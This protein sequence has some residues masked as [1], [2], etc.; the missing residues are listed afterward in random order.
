MGIAK[1]MPL[2]WPVRLTMA[3]LMPTKNSEIT[4]MKASGISLYRI[5]VPILG[6]AALI[7]VGVF[8][9]QDRIL[10]TSNKK[11]MEIKDVIKKG[12]SK[13]YQSINHQWLLGRGNR[14]YHFLSYD[15][16]E[17]TIQ[18][19]YLYDVSDENRMERI[20]VAKNATWRETFTGKDGQRKN[21]WRFYEG[22]DKKFRDMEVEKFRTFDEA[23]FILPEDY[24]FFARENK[25]PQL[26]SYAELNKYI[27]ELKK[28]GLDTTQ[29]SVISGTKL[30]WPVIT[31]ILT[32]I[33][34]PFSFKMGKQGAL[35]GVCISFIGCIIFWGVMSTF[36]ALGNTGVL[37]PF[38]A[39][40]APN[41]LF[42]L[43]GV[44]FLLNVRS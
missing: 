29:A 1:P 21:R 2:Y 6:V 41:I 43:V 30:S 39:A 32:L 17:R 26:M 25:T 4:A 20:I 11:A 8:L 28:S 35:Y 10:P 3:V 34:I 31:L 5:A 12:P 40:W 24:D 33:G 27:D 19:I 9:M 42:C 44:Y 14:F 38:L 7:C 15:E 16:P 23:D 37:S 36:R 18:R 22:W 13:T